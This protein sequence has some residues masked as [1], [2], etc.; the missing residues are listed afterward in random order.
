MKVCSFYLINAKSKQTYRVGFCL[1]KI[2][3]RVVIYI[4]EMLKMIDGRILSN[5]S[6]KKDIISDKPNSR[7]WQNRKKVNKTVT[8]AKN[9]V[10]NGTGR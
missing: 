9:A 5:F 1:M 4:F 10:S 2:G 6:F 3:E 8:L 7:T